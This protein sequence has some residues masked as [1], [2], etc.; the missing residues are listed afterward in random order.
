MV[1]VLWTGSDRFGHAV[2]TSLHGLPPNLTH[3]LKIHLGRF[4][5]PF[6][7]ARLIGSGG[8]SP[9]SRFS[10]HKVWTGVKWNFSSAQL[11][12][13]YV[14]GKLPISRVRM[15]NF[16]RIRRKTKKVMAFDNSGM[17]A[18]ACDHPQKGVNYHLSLP[19]LDKP[20]VV[21]KLSNWEAQICSFSRI[22]QKIKITAI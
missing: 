22:G 9:L 2:S 10:W 8:N 20:Y 12:D 16:T 21:G 17:K 18:V 3:T 13:W 1:T 7:P 4:L 6:R 19:Q 5:S 14:D 15:W 11:Q